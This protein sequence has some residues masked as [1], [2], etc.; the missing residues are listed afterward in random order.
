MARPSAAKRGYGRRW[1]RLRL[2]VLSRD[3]ICVKCNSPS[4]E[5]DHI[6]PKPNGDDSMDNLQGLCKSCHS[7]KT[8]KEMRAHEKF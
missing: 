5:V 4:E 1:Q 2:M 3:P 8:M 6:I 7:S